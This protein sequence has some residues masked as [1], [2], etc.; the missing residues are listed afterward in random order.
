MRGEHAGFNVLWTYR[1]C[2][3]CTLDLAEVH[4]RQDEAFEE[5]RRHI[6]HTFS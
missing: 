6:E 3:L 2:P 1:G 4:R 5:A